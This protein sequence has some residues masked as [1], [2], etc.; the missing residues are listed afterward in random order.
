MQIGQYYVSFGFRERWEKLLPNFIHRQ[1]TAGQDVA[2]QFKA[3]SWMAATKWLYPAK[4]GRTARHP[5][6]IRHLQGAV[7]PRV[8]D[9]GSILDVARIEHPDPSRVCVPRRFGQG[10]LTA[11][12]VKMEIWAWLVVAIV[13]ASLVLYAT[14][15]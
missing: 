11:H 1:Y 15:V 7:M 4:S 5:F 2:A 12:G 8:V 3:L 6:A 9:E 14:N 10:S 13:I